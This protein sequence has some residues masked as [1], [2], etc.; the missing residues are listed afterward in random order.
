MEINTF[1][2]GELPGLRLL[3]GTFV[4][5]SQWLHSISPYGPARVVLI[6][7]DENG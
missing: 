6:L 2:L 1:H 4:N 5:V 3:T 7:H